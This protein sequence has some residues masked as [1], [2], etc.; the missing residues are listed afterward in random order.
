[1]AAI[2]GTYPTTAASV[3]EWLSALNL[4]KHEAAL[5][6]AGITQVSQLMG[7]TDEQLIAA[8]IRL[9]GQRKRL[10]AASRELTGQSMEVEAP[11]AALQPPP[12]AAD[13]AMDVDATPG[14][15]VAAGSR[16]PPPSSS[17]A[18]GGSEDPPLA[19]PQG[20]RFNSTSSIYINSTIIKPDIDEIIFCVAVVIHD[21]IEQGEQMGVE[22]RQR[23]HYFSE[24]NNPLYADPVPQ[25]EKKAKREIP[26]EETIFHTIRSVRAQF[27]AIRR[28]AIFGGAQFSAARNS[29]SASLSTALSGVRV[30]ALP[31]GVPHRLSGVHR[32][33]GGDVGGADPVHVVAPDPARRPHPRAEGV[34]RPLAPQRRLLVLLPDVHA[35]G[36]QP[37]RE[38]VPRADRL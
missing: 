4:S 27:G 22:I 7:L 33:A 13:G 20:K 15:A 11:A 1:M 21:R 31:V 6:G 16:T 26:T 17:G 23:F 30:R 38:E 12:A 34:G 2:G 35:Q 28:R 24:E 14:T 10:I 9:V 36:D 25:Q 29:L 19:D 3:A 5:T 18:A 32:A 37:P 8:D